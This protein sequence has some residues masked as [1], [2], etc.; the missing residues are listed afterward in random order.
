MVTGNR[1]GPVSQKADYL[2]KKIAAIENTTE[3][4]FGDKF[5]KLLDR[6][7]YI[8]DS[9]PPSIAW[10]VLVSFRHDI[11]FELAH[12]IQDAHYRDGWDL[13]NIRPYFLICETFGINKR[14]FM[15]KYQDPAYKSLTISEFKKTKKLGVENFPALMLRA[16]DRMVLISKGYVKPDEFEKKL[17]EAGKSLG[18]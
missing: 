10:N 8:S 2:K 1:V 13:N 14:G 5:K 18:Y 15:N 4:R 12:A 16:D 7:E 11:R 3:A 9:L 6:G 17:Q